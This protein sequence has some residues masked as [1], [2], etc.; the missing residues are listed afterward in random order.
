MSAAREESPVPQAPDK[1]LAPTTVYCGKLMSPE[2]TSS[3]M[4]LR[5]CFVAV[6]RILEKSAEHRDNEH[7]SSSLL[8]GRIEKL[9]N[10]SDERK[11]GAL[12]APSSPAASVRSRSAAGAF[13]ALRRR[14]W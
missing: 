2:F 5:E 10:G 13:P 6:E 1:R 4:A 7:R 9:L 3:V 11:S 14:P 8:A 12:A